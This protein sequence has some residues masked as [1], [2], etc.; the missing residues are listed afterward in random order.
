MVTR[1]RPSATAAASTTL[2]SAPVS[3]SP[4]TVWQSSLLSKNSRGT[5]GPRFSSSLY[6]M[7]RA[8]RYG[9]KPL[10]SDL[11]SVCDASLNVLATQVRVRCKDIL[12]GVSA[13]KEV[14]D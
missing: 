9:N 11:G 6:F 5:A 13:R 8:H 12:H 1:I 10:A 4:C 2:S 7:R 3:P 14:K